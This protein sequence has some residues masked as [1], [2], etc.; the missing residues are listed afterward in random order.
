PAQ[1][2]PP[3]AGERPRGPGRWKA[4]RHVRTGAVRAAPRRREGTERK[5]VRCGDRARL[6]TPSPSVFRG[7][8]PAPLTRRRRSPRFAL[9]AHC[10]RR[11]LARFHAFAVRNTLEDLVERRMLGNRAQLAK[12]ELGEA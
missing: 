1:W 5:A 2:R 3:G 7:G 6:A 4:R 8:A 11:T 12:Q 10:M 9:G